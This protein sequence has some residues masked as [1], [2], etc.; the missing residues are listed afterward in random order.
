ME[1]IETTANEIIRN[2]T[3]VNVHVYPSASC[4]ELAHVSDQLK[5]SNSFI[6]MEGSVIPYVHQLHTLDFHI[7]LL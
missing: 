3:P 2:S 6:A 7:K 5:L 4:P 1:W